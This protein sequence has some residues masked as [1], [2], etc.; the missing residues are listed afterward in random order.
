MK[1]NFTSILVL[2]MALSM[3]TFAQHS[4]HYGFRIGANFS[5]LEFSDI[6]VGD[7]PQSELPNYNQEES[8]RLGF[9]FG[10]FGEFFL[11]DHISLQP[12]V[13]Y[14]S[15]GEKYEFDTYSYSTYNVETDSYDHTTYKDSFKMDVIQVPLLANFYIGDSF[16]VSV[17]P[18]VGVGILEWERG[19]T[20]EEFQFSGLGGFG[21]RLSDRINIDAR[22]SYGLTDA[23][24]FNNIG[25]DT[26]TTGGAD[27]SQESAGLETFST[28]AKNH[29]AQ[30]TF[31]YRI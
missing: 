7:E 21:V 31:S 4:N 28:N 22:V 12:E 13:Q 17:G 29:Y 2:F 16:Y 23:I 10:F 1:I 6:M 9:T 25:S 5:D 15:Q 27:A 3:N 11:G 30:L 24:N 14:S 19:T 20:A 26:Y 8:Y 18:Q